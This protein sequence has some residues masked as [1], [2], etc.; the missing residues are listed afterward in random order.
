MEPSV[1]GSGGRVVGHQE[2]VTVGLG[3]HVEVALVCAIVR[4]A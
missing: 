4:D 2:F 3:R 1:G